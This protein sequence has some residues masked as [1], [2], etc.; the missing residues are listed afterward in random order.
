MDKIIYYQKLIKIGFK[1]AFALKKVFILRILF[2]IL[3]NLMLLYAWYLMFLNFP[4][5]HSWTFNDFMFMTGLVILTFSVW[6]IFF[7]GI[8]IH[9]MRLIENG[10]LDSFLVIPRHVLFNVGCSVC[11]PSG[12]GDFI[13]GVLLMFFSGLVSFSNFPMVLCFAFSGICV[14]L[15]LNIL[16]SSL[17]FFIKNSSDIGERIFFMFFNIAGYPGSIYTGYLKLFFCSLLPIGFISIL[18]VEL[19]H[20]FS[21]VTL[22]YL[23]TASICF[24]SFS[25]FVFSYGLK[26]YESGNRFNIH[27]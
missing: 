23:I 25:I 14:F 8:G 24:L 26:K 11:D 15:A 7:R 16:I 18:P 1:Q 17:P 12:I 3:N 21:A 27:Y 20:T 19:V 6:P 5:I 10:E 4:I 9:L 13:T 22:I 2:M